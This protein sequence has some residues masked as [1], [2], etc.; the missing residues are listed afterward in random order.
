MPDNGCR[1]IHSVTVGDVM[2]KDMYVHKK[3]CGY[4]NFTA[5]YLLSMLVKEGSNEKRWIA[6]DAVEYL[7]ALFLQ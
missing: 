1:T 7:E 3:E 6:F 5:I 4:T 2:F